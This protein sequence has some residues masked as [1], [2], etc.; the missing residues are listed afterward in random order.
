VHVWGLDSGNTLRLAIRRVI[1]I[2]ICDAGLNVDVESLTLRQLHDFTGVTTNIAVTRLGSSEGHE[3]PRAEMLNYMNAPDLNVVDALH[4]SMSIPILFC[5]VQF[6]NGIYT[7]GAVLNNI[8]VDGYEK[9]RTLILCLRHACLSATAGLNGY[10]QALLSTIS[11]CNE[12]SLKQFCYRLHLDSGNI[13]S[14]SFNA[15]RSEIVHGV[16]VGMVQT[17]IYAMK[18][19]N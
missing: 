1:E 5:P 18:V 13:S 10:L 12:A 19:E 8:P 7:D 3:R 14:I 15:S 2:G 11:M 6:R 17:L 16:L 4:M 9:D